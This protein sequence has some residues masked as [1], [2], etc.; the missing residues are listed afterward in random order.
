MALHSW[1]NGENCL[2]AKLKRVENRTML[3]RPFSIRSLFT[4]V[5]LYLFGWELKSHQRGKAVMIAYQNQSWDLRSINKHLMGL[6][7]KICS[8][9][10]V[11][12]VFSVGWTTERWKT[13]KNKRVKAIGSLKSI[14][15]ILFEMRDALKERKRARKNECFFYHYYVWVSG[16]DCSHF[17]YLY[18]WVGSVTWI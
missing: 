12:P 7:M 5:C 14:K 16:F 11:K 15:R 10:Q 8:H 6:S 4:V 13:P 2:W 17:Q 3:E 9:G 18:C 1:K